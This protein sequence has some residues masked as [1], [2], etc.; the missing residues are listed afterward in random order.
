MPL[1]WVPL[2]PLYDNVSDL[3]RK[4]FLRGAECETVDGIPLLNHRKRGIKNTHYIT[5]AIAGVYT[6]AV[7]EELVASHEGL[8]CCR[9]RHHGEERG[10]V[11]EIFHSKMAL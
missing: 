1:A 10:S 3:P 8:S 5:A 7:I 11:K 9:R 6:G 4:D 2:Q